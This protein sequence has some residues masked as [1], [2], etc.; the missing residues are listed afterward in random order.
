MTLGAIAKLLGIS[1]ERVRQ[2]NERNSN[3]IRK[4]STPLITSICR[5]CNKKFSHFHGVIRVTCSRKCRGEWC[6]KNVKKECH[7]CRSDDKLSI[8]GRHRR[9]RYINRW[10]C[11]QCNTK[12]HK[13]WS[14]TKNAKLLQSKYRISM[15]GKYPQKRQARN[16]INRAVQ[17]GQIIKPSECSVCGSTKRL[18]GHHADYSKP[19]KVK[20]VC[21]GCHSDIHKRT[22]ER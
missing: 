14:I 18:D 21:R 6:E 11:R 1:T 4:F 22:T 16:M 7:I 3:P 5:N 19:M 10:I 13:K 12:I 9:F 20:W 8:S 17:N 2:L 15:D